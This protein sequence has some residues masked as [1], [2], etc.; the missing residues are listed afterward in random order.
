MSW[1]K[2]L[3]KMGSAVGFAPTDG[4]TDFAVTVGNPYY[5]TDSI[6]LNRP[7]LIPATVIIEMKVTQELFDTL[8]KLLT[9][10]EE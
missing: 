8:R 6:G 5:K 1:T 4:V 2:T 3:L 10:V 9:E 7:V